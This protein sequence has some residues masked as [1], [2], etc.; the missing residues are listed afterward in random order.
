[1]KE[2]TLLELLQSIPESCQEATIQGIRM[3]MIDISIKENLLALDSEGMSFHE[4]ILKNGTFVFS[5]DG[6]H[7]LQTLFKVYRQVQKEVN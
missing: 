4:C 5:M 2:E 7:R 3:E 1:M 6:K